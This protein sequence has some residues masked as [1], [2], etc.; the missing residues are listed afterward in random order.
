M[1]VLGTDKVQHYRMGCQ[2]EKAII[3]KLAKMAK[4][5]AWSKIRGNRSDL[6]KLSE[7]SIM[8]I[9]V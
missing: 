6:K 7:I 4:N 3:T 2:G 9:R 1:V 8:S 5:H